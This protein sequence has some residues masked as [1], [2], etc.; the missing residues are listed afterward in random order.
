MGKIGSVKKTFF[1]TVSAVCVSFLCGGVLVARAEEHYRIG[2]LANRGDEACVKEWTSTARYLTDNIPGTVFT[3]V[4]LSSD[5]IDR[6]VQ[7]RGVD[8]L[9]ANPALYVEEQMLRGAQRIATLKSRGTTEGVSVYGSVVFTRADRADIRTVY[10]LKKKNVMMVDDNSFGGWIIAWRELL[11][12]GVDPYRSFARLNRGLLQDKVVYA[13]RD[14]VVD[15]GIVR[16]G[17]LEQMASAGRIEI[18]AFRI[19]PVYGGSVAPNFPF[20]TS[21]RLYPE[22]AFAKL[23]HTPVNVAEEVMRQLLRIN[24]DDLAAINGRYWGW[25]VPLN[26]TPVDECLKEVRWGPYKDYGKVT[27]QSVVRQ[28][29]PWMIVILLL[30]I[31][32]GSF[33]ARALILNRR[34][35]SSREDILRERNRAQNYLDVAGVMMVALDTRGI[36]TMVN[37]K[38]CEVLGCSEEGILGRE[39][40]ASFIPERARPQVETIF[41]TLTTGAAATYE[42]VE[43]EVITCSGTIRIIAWHNVALKDVT[44]VTRGTLSSGEDITERK[45]M[46]DEL[47]RHE[48][49]LAKIMES[50]TQPFYVLD[51]HTYELRFANSAAR[52]GTN[53]MIKTCYALTHHVDKPCSG[54]H[55]CPLE[56]VK[57]T[58]EPFVVEHVHYDASGNPRNVEVYGYP[59]LDEEGNVFQMVEYSLD[60]TERKKAEQILHESEEKYRGIVDNIGMGVALISPEMEILSLNNQM[61]KWNPR[62]DLK[63]KHICYR[64]FND[65]PRENICTY[66][67]TARTLKDG[68]VHEAVTETPM[69]GEIANYRVISSPIKDDAGKVVAAIEMVEDITERKRTEAA[70]KEYTDQVAA[71]NKELDDFTYIVSHDLKEPL[72]SIDAFS[73][74]IEYDYKAVLPAEGNEYI[75]RIRANVTRMQTLID[76]LL[77]VSRIDRKKNPLEETDVAGLIS[78]VKARLEFSIKEKNARISIATVLPLVVADRVRLLEAFHNLISNAIKYNDK[79]E[80]RID[81]G[82]EDKGAVWEFFVK[83]NGPGIEEQYFEKIFQ[84][85]QRLGHR[86]DKEG[87]GAGLT[88]VKKIVEMHKG[89][90]W[91]GSRVGEGTTFY[92]TIPK[93][94]LTAPVETPGAAC[95]LETDPAKAAGAYN[96]KEA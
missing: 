86:D 62:I 17:I 66:C 61:Q 54:A 75:G 60:I 70:L 94:P 1:V 49:Y 46:E 83:D 4:P 52:R 90:I 11:L 39:W 38:T 89:R 23:E 3:V 43:N 35:V 34:L 71:I 29:W 76:D 10:D 87:S 14:G 67:P 95:S 16:T 82:C 77:E 19:I 8:F 2:V 84:I 92:F 64:S 72:R 22:W 81:I 93:V 96:T 57:K 59:I 44:G 63:S 27:L 28:Y 69:N 36:V 32:M 5:T 48:A 68:L 30:L 26:Y 45:S 40:I 74:F 7:E 47:A 18:N 21:T 41:Q 6:A 50:V 73:K 9:I 58:K 91:V 78:E 15:V 25:T 56:Q 53:P 51:A 12:S 31:A 80:P 33:M 79:P 65:P 20:R 88:I 85:F 55:V 37:R 13:V 42:H 24:P